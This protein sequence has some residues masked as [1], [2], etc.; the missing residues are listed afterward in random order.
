M[1]VSWVVSPDCDTL[2]IQEH[3]INQ[4]K[5]KGRIMDAMDILGAL[6]G[7][8]SGSGSRGGDML[9]DMMAGKS[10]QPA[11]RRAPV[12]QRQTRPKTIGDAARD[13]EDLLNVSTDHHS[14]RRQA[15]RQAPAPSPPPASRAP[16][17]A[18]MNA[19]AEVLIRAMVCA[20]KSDGQ[21]TEAEQQEILKR[22]EHVG[23]EEI[24]FL[25]AEFAKQVDA[26]D[27]AWSVPLG[28]EQQV[29]QISLIAIDLDEQKEAEY[30]ADLAHGLRLD[31]RVCN[32][33][34]TK[35]GAP[36]IFQE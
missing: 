31:P 2:L 35:L 34:H 19:Q 18:Q 21:V 23:Q 3:A 5:T 4:T 26:R 9:K 10:R 29:Y 30:L 1:F 32:Q 11:P 17:Q 7:K 12:P 13:L 24:N 6:L 15:P 16:E 8:K 22:L 27:L 33:I 25:R 36:V 14:Q 20:A 28:M